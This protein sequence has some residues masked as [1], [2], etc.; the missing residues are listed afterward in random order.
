MIAALPQIV[1]EIVHGEAACYLVQ[2][3]QTH[4]RNPTDMQDLQDNRARCILMLKPAI[5]AVL[6][7]KLLAQSDSG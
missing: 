3:L 5:L 4:S 6:G 2:A 7:G 1:L